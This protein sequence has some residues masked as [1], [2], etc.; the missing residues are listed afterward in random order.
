MAYP[1]FYA[2]ERVGT[3]YP[4]QSLQAIQAGHQAGYAPSQ[5]DKQ[6]IILLLVDM[7]VDFVHPQGSLSVPGAVD[8]TRRTIE[9][10]YRHTDKITSI[11]ASLDS[12][13][14]LQIFSPAWWVDPQGQ[15]P[16]AY[17]TISS[18]EVEQGQW[19]ALYEADWSKRYVQQLE[20]QARKQLMIWP[21]H[22]LI[23]T[24]GHNLMPAL[25]E[26]LAFHAS[27]RQTQ[28]IFLQK[29]DEPLTE[30]YSILEPE[31][32]VPRK[33]ALN[34]TFLSTLASYDLIY[35]AGQAKSHCVLE[36]VNSM[37]NCF[38]KD[39]IGRIRLLD[40]AMSSV[41]HPSID[42]EALAEEAFVRHAAQGLVRRA[43][44]DPLG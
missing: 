33:A 37:M 42:F 16:T 44:A 34:T 5:Q 20:L 7:Q 3:L 31:V 28:P 1:D 26:A 39:I 14:P 11:A 30:H 38:S 32:K 9:F 36:S 40:D 19:Q 22:T 13:L 43:T 18:A 41:A 8:D 23:G 4:P 12:H 15:H 10:I 27:A 25:Y 17:T 6:R 21:Y 35:I 29:G 2:S 24:E